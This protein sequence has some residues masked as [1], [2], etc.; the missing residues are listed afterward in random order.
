MFGE[1]EILAEV[2]ETAARD[3][4]TSGLG[5]NANKNEGRNQTSQDR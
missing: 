1:S 5:G 3:I 4:E 2:T